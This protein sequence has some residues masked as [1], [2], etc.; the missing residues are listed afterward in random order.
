MHYISSDD[1]CDVIERF[2]T[3]DSVKI[4]D[5]ILNHLKENP[6][7][8]VTLYKVNTNKKYY[9]DDVIDF[10]SVN[11]KSGKPCKI[12]LKGNKEFFKELV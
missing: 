12:V 8:T 11:P 9:G 6:S 10:F 7:D 2:E 3:F 1:T 5:S 4:K